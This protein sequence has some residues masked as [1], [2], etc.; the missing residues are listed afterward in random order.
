MNAAQVP[1]RR[2]FLCPS[3]WA[4]AP[5]PRRSRERTRGWK[6]AWFLSTARHRGG[7][8]FG[9]SDCALRAK[10]SEC[11]L[12]GRRNCGRA[13]GGDGNPHVKFILR[14]SDEILAAGTVS[15]DSGQSAFCAHSES[16]K[17]SELRVRKNGRFR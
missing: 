1:R 14:L 5:T 15:Q 8:H 2:F 6:A 4:P 10:S 12:D 9:R 13:Y 17:N 3:T 7:R 16:G 11:D